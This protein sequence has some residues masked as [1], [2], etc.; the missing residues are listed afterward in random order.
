MIYETVSKY[1]RIHLYLIDLLYCES[2]IYQ[3]LCMALGHSLDPR[4]PQLGINQKQDVQPTI[5]DTLHIVV[6]KFY[7]VGFTNKK[8][9][10][11]EMPGFYRLIPHSK[12]W[13]MPYFCCN[14]LGSFVISLFLL[15]NSSGW[16]PWEM[17]LP[18]GRSLRAVVR[19]LV[20]TRT[21]FT[22]T[23]VNV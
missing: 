11:Y 10:L 5:G 6:S 16:P 14:Q 4:R 12:F 17:S 7:I 20:R 3:P 19:M 22:V 9:K 13:L 2:S 8:R 18:R 23:L 15:A 1:V 21:S